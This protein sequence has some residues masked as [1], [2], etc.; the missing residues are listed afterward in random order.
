M[1][2]A[3]VTPTSLRG[4]YLYDADF[5][6]VDLSGHSVVGAMLEGARF[7]GATLVQLHA[8]NTHMA[9]AKFREVDLTGADL[10]FERHR[11]DTTATCNY[12]Q[13]S[14]S[15]LAGANLSRCPMTYALFD[16]ADMTG[17]NLDRAILVAASF[18]GTD[19]R[20]AD[21]RFAD[22]SR[23]R[24]EGADLRGTNLSFTNLSGAN[25]DGAQ[26]D[27]TTIWRGTRYTQRTRWFEGERKKAPL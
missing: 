17:A 19:L 24:F 6:G 15:T 5:R 10:S 11:K 23:A 3:A 8:C 13:F 26:W 22:A 1:R 25:L 16:G 12:T 20:G 9:H 2:A 18:K 7:D 27:D 4:K 14:Q 21:L